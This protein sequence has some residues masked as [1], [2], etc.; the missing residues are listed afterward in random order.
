MMSLHSCQRVNR[1]KSKFWFGWQSG[2]A[3]GNQDRSIPVYQTIGDSWPPS[4]CLE[5]CKM[6]HHKPNMS[7]L[8]SAWLVWVAEPFAAVHRVVVFVTRQHTDTYC[9]VFK[10]HRPVWRLRDA[11][12]L[13]WSHL[14]DMILFFSLYYH[15][16]KY[17]LSKET[18]RKNN[19]YDKKSKTEN[20]IQV[21]ESW[22]Q[23]CFK[24]L[25][26][27]HFTPWTN[28]SNWVTNNLKLYFK[29]LFAQE[30]YTWKKHVGITLRKNNTL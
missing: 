16:G 7:Q 20:V 9:C 19:V 21:S 27:L 6:Q 14:D 28:W 26:Y 1:G 2:T 30:E 17:L 18:W 10:W 11:L 3:S 22:Q 24:F 23:V 4:R 5:I 13:W 8:F 15:L 29:E 25:I 12:A